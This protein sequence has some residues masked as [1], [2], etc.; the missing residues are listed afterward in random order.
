M[1][2]SCWNCNDLRIVAGSLCSADPPQC[3]ADPSGFG[4]GHW[5]TCNRMN[6]HHAWLSD[7]NEGTPLGISREEDSG[8]LGLQGRPNMP[9]RMLCESPNWVKHD[10]LWKPE[11]SGLGC[12]GVPEDQEACIFHS[13]KWKI[14]MA[15]CCKKRRVNSAQQGSCG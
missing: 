13:Q 7:P 11:H 12:M 8:G 4:I 10:W 14:S 15:E 1:C 2:P 6:V 9:G 5:S 3:V